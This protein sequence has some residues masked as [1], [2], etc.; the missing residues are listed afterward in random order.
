MAWMHKLRL[1]VLAV[2]VGAG[3]CVLAL[4]SWAALPVW[5]VI[6]VALATA[7]MVVNTM[8]HKLAQPACM[9]CG[10]NLTGEPI[11]LYGIICPDC[12]AITQSSMLPEPMDLAHNDQADTDDQSSA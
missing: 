3:L 8:T 2:L 5:P 1:R 4:V 12:G 7:A 11:G 9:S 10:K 6:G